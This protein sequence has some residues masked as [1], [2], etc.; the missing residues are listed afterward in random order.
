MKTLTFEVTVEVSELPV[1]DIAYLQDQVSR[2]IIS[3]ERLDLGPVD[4]MGAS[5][6]L[7]RVS[8]S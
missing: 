7:L 4:E 6:R 1:V 5:A 3:S 8:E 2:A